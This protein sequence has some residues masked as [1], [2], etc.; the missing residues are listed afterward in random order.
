[1]KKY[2]EPKLELLSFLTEDMMFSD[3]NETDPDD[4]EFVIY[5]I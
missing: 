4:Y 3:E 5:D 1:M 2:E